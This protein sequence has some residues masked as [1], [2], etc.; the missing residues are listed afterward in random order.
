[1]NR[2]ILLSRLFA[3]SSRWR[4]VTVWSSLLATLAGGSALAQPG[5]GP[6]QQAPPQVASRQP[7]QVFAQAAAS[8]AFIM[9]QPPSGSIAYQ[10][11]Q[12]DREIGIGGT[13]A[14]ARMGH[15]AGQTVGRNQ[16]I[17]HFEVMPYAFVDNT[18][19]Y[20]D[21]RFY[22]TNNGSVG[23]S[24]GVGVRQFLPTYNSIIG[25]GVFYDG[26][27]TR[28]K[29]FT[30]L[31]LSLE[32]L[33][34]FLDVRTNLY[35]NT[36][37]KS[38]L[39]GTSF[40]QGSEHFVDDNIA[41]NTQTRR[42]A[43]SDG[44]DV[45]FTVPVPGE[46]F[47]AINLE[48]S[49]GGY[50]YVANDFDLD[51]ATGY[52]LRLDGDFLASTV[53]TFLEFTS[54]KV[55]NNNVIFGADLN[56]YHDVQRRPRLGHNQFNRM[57]E[58]VRRN[59]TAVAIED[60]VVNPDELAINPDT[61]NPYI[62]LHVRNIVPADPAFPNFPAP[63]GDGSIDTP[64]QFIDEAQLDPRDADII[65]VHAGSIFNDMP[66]VIEP[67]QQ[68]LGEG[69]E[70]LIQVSNPLPKSGV[71]VLPDATGGDELPILQ[72]TLGTAVTLADNSVFAGFEINN[73][74]GTA[75]FGDSI[76]GSEV[77]D[78]T[79]TD[80]N[81]AAAHGVHL[82]DTT[83]SFRFEQIQT[84]GVEGTDLFIDGGNSTST[85]LA[86]SS[87]TPR[88]GP[89]SSRIRRAARSISP[90]TTPPRLPPALAV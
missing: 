40:I 84:S 41:F 87:P 48:A 8:D 1:M 16:S 37:R 22:T 83:G 86:D 88:G 53:H 60:T 58:W 42:A 80:T 54:D 2:L 76:N 26:D 10:Q 11:P 82:V 89:S 39:L 49:A 46:V 3:R 52:R 27:G 19:W 57:S 50:H 78:V 67:N 65:Y 77:R 33:S 23:G 74:T 25:A 90:A 59:Y 31:G 69:V 13:G 6:A 7:E 24:G 66:V 63:A 32:Y 55:F 4:R 72:D 29:T 17:T 64:Y 21:G 73:T 56:Y 20:T 81:G 15:I 9:N 14:L 28:A 47:Q 79:I 36:G 38:A 18:M 43:G 70:H 51:D 35:A 5:P 71:I 44:L 68:V 62:V 12:Y 75:I 34:E 85:G 30:Q 61:G 45:T